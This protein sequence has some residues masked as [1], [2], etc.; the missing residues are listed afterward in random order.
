MENRAQGALLIFFC[1]AECAYAQAEQ[2]ALQ[3]VLGASRA[4]SAGTRQHQIIEQRNQQ[5]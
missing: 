1:A 5:T 2:P 3:Q 4:G